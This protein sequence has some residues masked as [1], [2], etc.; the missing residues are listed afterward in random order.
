MN[1]QAPNTKDQV[2][3][4][5]K[6]IIPI[7]MIS[8]FIIL[9]TLAILVYVEA[10]SGNISVPMSPLKILGLE[11]LLLGA[12]LAGFVTERILSALINK[13]KITGRNHPQ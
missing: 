7:W 13:S 3:S 11:F 9:S 12:I 10:L 2:A 6:W 8:T 5:P 1:K 4:N